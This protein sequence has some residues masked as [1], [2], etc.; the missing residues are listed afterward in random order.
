MS[1]RTERVEEMLREE[2]SVLLQRELKDPRVGFV[3]ITGAEVTTD[4]RHAKVFIS[5]LG[6]PEE[7]E[8]SL[9]A[10]NRGRGF[11]RTEIGKRAHLRTVP[12]LRFLEDETT[13]T[14][15]RIFKLL[16]DVK[17]TEQPEPAQDGQVE[18]AQ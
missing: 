7:T 15:S 3:T 2:I 10:L 12:E 11:L 6:T 9:E 5:V 17:L 1:R 8:R 18:D 16:E 14:G 13:Q 4:L